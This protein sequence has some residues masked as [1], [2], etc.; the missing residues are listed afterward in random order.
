M[1]LY[2]Q[3]QCT[4]HSCKTLNQLQLL[5]RLGGR[6]VLVLELFLLR[7]EEQGLEV[8][9]QRAASEDK[10]IVEKLWPK[11]FNAWKE[12]EFWSECTELTPEMQRGSG[13]G[14]MC[15]FS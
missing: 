5:L 15:L 10:S 9:S 12:K 6:A 7:V 11:L 2:L 8:S 13:S 3:V 14:S 1:S 4:V